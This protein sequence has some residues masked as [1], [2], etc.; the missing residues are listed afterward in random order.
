MVGGGGTE[1]RR[2]EVDGVK[3]KK[4][5]V[6]NLSLIPHAEAVRTEIFFNVLNE[7]VNSELWTQNHKLRIVDSELWT[8]R[9]NVAVLKNPSGVLSQPSDKT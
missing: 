1:E 7:V 2:M 3:E 8:H 4:M 5:C 6:E 9:R